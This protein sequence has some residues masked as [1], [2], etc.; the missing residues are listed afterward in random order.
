MKELALYFIQFAPK[1]ESTLY[2]EI[3]MHLKDKN[4]SDVLL[5]TLNYDCL[6]DGEF[7]RSGIDYNYLF[8][9]YKGTPLLKLHG[10]CNWYIDIHNVN[11]FVVIDP[12]I[13]I[14]GKIKSI[15]KPGDAIK[16]F[17]G[18][19][20]FPPVICLYTKQKPAP[21]GENFFSHLHEQWKK[22]VLNAR[23]IFI[24]GAKPNT[25]DKHIWEPLSD[26]LAEIYYI[27][28]EKSCTEWSIRTNRKKRTHII[29][30]RFING[31]NKLLEL[32]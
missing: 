13:R 23:Q 10:S 16:R 24:I 30:D 18:D 22:L 6:L 26:T 20:P 17:K 1:E 7:T 11:K 3:L 28:N 31:K 4:R 8:P 25:T 15:S 21:I 27:G 14:Y 9:P 2:K 32:L 19:H 5:A 12:T 29:G